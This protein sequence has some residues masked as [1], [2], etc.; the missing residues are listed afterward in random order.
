MEQAEI[1]RFLQAIQGTKYGLVYQIPLFTGLREGEVLGL[2]WDCIDFQHNA[3][4]STSSFRKR[5]RWAVLTAWPRQRT[6]VT[7]RS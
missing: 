5:K 2:T 6:A 3:I 1:T 4:Y 7:A